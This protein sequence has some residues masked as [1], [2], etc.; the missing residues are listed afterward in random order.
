MGSG[1]VAPVT[2]LH[3][4]AFAFQGKYV[5]HPMGEN[6]LLT[7]NMLIFLNLGGQSLPLVLMAPCL[8]L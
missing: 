5:G 4:I 7:K 2:S 6:F 8:D 3:P 1:Y